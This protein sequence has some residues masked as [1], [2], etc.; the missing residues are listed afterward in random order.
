MK[1]ASVN[2]LHSILVLSIVLSA[3][4]TGPGAA[5]AKPPGMT[6]KAE[7]VLV[8]AV[9]T[10]PALAAKVEA[11]RSA[12]QAGDQELVRTLCDEFG[13]AA[14]P[15]PSPTSGKAA[16]ASHVV[17]RPE[18]AGRNDT[19]GTDVLV[20]NINWL[21]SNP[22]MAS[23]TDGVLYAVLED[24]APGNYYLDFYSSEDDGY[25]WFY[26][27]SV[28]GLE[29]V[30]NPSLAIGEGT[31]NRL[32]VAY[33][34]GSGT[35]SAAIHVHWEDL[36]TGAT[37]LAVVENFP[38]WL[39]HPQ[40]CVDSPEYS[41]WWPYLTYTKGVPAKQDRYDL[42]FSRSLDRGETW[43][44]PTVVATDVS[45][46]CR[47]DI[48]FGTAGLF[49]AYTRY[50]T[51][52]ENDVCL[53]RS[54]S[55]GTTWDPELLLAH[56]TQDET[57]PRIAA[58]NGGDAVVVAFTREYSP[59]DTDIESYVSENGGDSWNLAYLP[60]TSNAETGVDLTVS[61]ELD[62]IHA[63][64][65]SEHDIHYTWA[66]W[67]EPDSW[68]P[69]EVMNDGSTA[70][71]GKRPTVAANPRKAQEGCVAWVDTRVEIEYHVFFDAAYAL[72]GYLLILGDFALLPAVQP[73][74]AWKEQLGYDVQVLTV[75]QI[76]EAYPYGDD[77][78]R[79]WAF[80]HD[81][82][83]LPRYVLLI[84]DIDTIPMRTLYPDGDPA[85]P[86]SDPRHHNGLGYGTDYYYAEHTM[87]S[88]DVDG[89]NR[90]G[91]FTDD[92][93]DYSPDLFVGRLP[94]NDPEPVQ[95]ICSNIVTF[96]QDTGEW[97]RR[98]LLAHGFLFQPPEA[99]VPGSDCASMAEYLR[100]TLLVGLG[101][102]TTTLYEKGGVGPSAYP[103]ADGLSQPV[104]E[105]YCGLQAYGVINCAAH[106]NGTSL[107]GI[108]WLYDLNG[109]GFCDLAE[110]WAYNSYS[111]RDRIAAHPAQSFM[112]LNGCSSAPILGDDP[113]FAASP[114]RSLYLIRNPR[115][116][117]AFKDY[118][119]HGA[120]GVIGA[121]A[122]SRGS[123][124]WISPASGG[125]LSLNQYFYEFLVGMGVPVGDAFHYAQWAYVE[126]HS[127]EREMRVF[128][129]YGDP[130]L[131]LNGISNTKRGGPRLARQ[132]VPGQLGLRE[133][134]ALADGWQRESGGPVSA[135]G[136]P[137]VAAAE[138]SRDES[139]I[140]APCAE[141]PECL[142]VT[143]LVEVPGGGMLLTGLA[144]ND[145]NGTRGV[146]FGSTDGWDP[147]TMR[148][149][150]FLQ[151]L[152]V[153]FRTAA[154]VLLVGGMAG[155]PP[156][157][158]HG[159][160]YRSV[161]GGL[162]W[163]E[164]LGIPAGMVTDFCQDMAG[165]V[166]AVCGLNGE[167]WSSVDDGVSWTPEIAFMDG[168][169]INSIM[170]A[171]GGRY[172]AT[173]DRLEY[174]SIIRSDDGRSWFPVGGIEEVESAYD[175]VELGGRLY[176]GVARF[177]G[178]R[179]YRSADLS[180]EWWSPLPAFPAAAG[181]VA[182]RCLAV[183]L[184]GD[185]LAGTSSSQAG[186]TTHLFTL[187]PAELVWHEYGGTVDLA[188][189]ITA[190][191]PVSG[192]VFIG[193]GSFNGNV[194]RCAGATATGV[195]GD[196]Q[197]PD[198]AF[199]LGQNHPNPFNP[200]T[201]IRYELPRASTVELAIYNVAGRLVRVLVD[202]TEQAAGRHQVTW[203]G[204]DGSGKRVPS[205]VYVY[206][207]EAGGLREARRMVLI[208]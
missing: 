186:N 171:S 126:N 114:L 90:W 113:N 86:P 180:G 150:D 87:A 54:N 143:S 116:A 11:L 195:P 76:F 25:T 100:T 67:D 96:E 102:T 117:L 70:A 154:G 142:T 167:I 149:I 183:G 163:Q 51:S 148:E 4:L 10:D 99:G 39:F 123:D 14:A 27:Y 34:Y 35:P 63:A 190:I 182:V 26:R 32:L 91:E 1:T 193:T 61:R 13:W 138:P 207:L 158:Y 174:D 22:V 16:G 64:F 203:D 179:V 135:A 94:F 156:A 45:A 192:T 121:S 119:L 41:A 31:V 89:D 12:K 98:A 28:H 30:S 145:T 134:L 18:L 108:R 204:L 131:V 153:I 47:P 130:S 165:K 118:L 125:S 9:P 140:W 24:V 56:H 78:E 173:L 68:A 88:W 43:Q 129:F 77:A 50:A 176:A 37:G 178:G 46:S 36:D 66:G 184:D 159:A 40:I 85:Y 72:G 191:L 15:E 44:A 82:V 109:S 58:V 81:R 164:R 115:P 101:W 208:Q 194:Y 23:T 187:D 144:A 84:G 73:L 120:V 8:E 95:A 198:F 97:K 202:G 166:W 168:P 152:R 161:D 177:D 38:H 103:C 181:A 136:R 5:V 92:S 107:N 132:T 83:P 111:R 172:F 146:I 162:S 49:I 80:L 188:D 62:R 122:G 2:L 157:E 29:E 52:Y 112:F 79:I 106:G 21:S 200:S 155:N 93:F 205:G 169:H 199:R 74:A 75:D 48:D 133:A 60:W 17:I 170:Q 55:L 105:S 160:I 189:R 19:P 127:L 196:D 7:T 20:D 151:S 137:L 6:G 59:T 185:I 197:T 69:I 33:E 128:N 124:N 206:R 201:T 65:L 147:W 104:Y 71:V 53:L 110:E 3:T 139:A 57:D 175:V 42:I 141:L